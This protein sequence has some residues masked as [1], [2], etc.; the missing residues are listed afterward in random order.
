[1]IYAVFFPVLLLTINR[2]VEVCVNE[3]SVESGFRDFQSPCYDCFLCSPVQFLYNIFMPLGTFGIKPT[4]EA[5]WMTKFHPLSLFPRQRLF[6]PLADEIAFYLGGEA[7][8]EGEDLALDVI[9]K[10]VVVFDGPYTA[11]LRHAN[12]Q[13]FHNHEEISAETGQLAANDDVVFVYFLQQEA[14][15]TLGVVFCAADGLLY[16]VVDDDILSFTEVVDFETL[17]LYCLFVAAYSDITVNHN[18]VIEICLFT[19]FYLIL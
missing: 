8:S 16:P 4:A 12:I 1:M 3:V 17:V 2:I 10:A 15:L 13:D 19:N 18:F 6:C 11:L 14:Q 7:E 9:T 5:M